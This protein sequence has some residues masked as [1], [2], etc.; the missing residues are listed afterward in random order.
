MICICETVHSN[1][2]ATWQLCHHELSMT[3]GETPFLRKWKSEANRKISDTRYR[4]NIRKNTYI[5][6][7]SIVV[8]AD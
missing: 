7:V 3:V 4:C 2:K 8:N 6:L 1:E 5:V